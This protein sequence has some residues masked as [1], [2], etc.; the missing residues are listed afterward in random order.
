MKLT[1]NGIGVED[2]G[3]YSPASLALSSF[4]YKNF[5]GS[6]D[7]NSFYL[8][9]VLGGHYYLLSGSSLTR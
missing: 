7:N 2:I 9:L 5:N 8:L 3:A 4:G 6:A 1:S